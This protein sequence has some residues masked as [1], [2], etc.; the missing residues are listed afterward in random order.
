MASIGAKPYRYSRSRGVYRG[1]SPKRK[2]GAVEFGLRYAHLDLSD[3]TINGGKADETSLGATWIV[4]ETVRIQLNH[5]RQQ[6][7]PNRNGLDQDYAVTALR[8]Q[9]NI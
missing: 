1:I 9:L 2:W 8:V 5:S 7:R 6:A 3:D 4:N